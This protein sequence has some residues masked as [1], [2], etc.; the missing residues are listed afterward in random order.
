MIRTSS[1]RVWRAWLF[2]SVAGTVLITLPDPDRRLFSISDSHGPGVTDLVGALVLITGWAVLDLHI[3]R[4]RHRLL[5]LRRRRLVLLVV[6]ALGGAVIIAWS[7]ERDAGIW[8]LL[9]VALLAGAQL[10]AAIVGTVRSGRRRP[11]GANHPTRVLAWPHDRQTGDAGC[12][13]RTRH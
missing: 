1:S 3:W 8:W 9:G 11:D 2:L 4:G 5:A 6:T 7:V 12:L 13:R 10:G